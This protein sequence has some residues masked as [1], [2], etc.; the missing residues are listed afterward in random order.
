[1][2]THIVQDGFMYLIDENKQARTVHVY[3]VKNQLIAS[4]EFCDDTESFHYSY[5]NAEEGKIDEGSNSTIYHDK[6]SLTDAAHWLAATH[7]EVG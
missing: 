3:T 6:R 2:K 4:G 7:P 5:R 1:M